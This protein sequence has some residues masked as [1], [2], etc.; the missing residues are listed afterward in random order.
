M[1]RSGCRMSAATP[2]YRARFWKTWRG[3]TAAGSRCYAKLP[4]RCGS[5]RAAIIACCD[6]AR[7]LADLDGAEKVGRVHLAEALSY[8]ALADEI[9]RAAQARIGRVC[10]NMLFD[11]V[12]REVPTT[13]SRCRGSSRACRSRTETPGGFRH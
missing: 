10:L 5:R 6:V 1:P 13:R 9:R 11:L 12:V 4:M 2:R 7:T 8:R 3:R